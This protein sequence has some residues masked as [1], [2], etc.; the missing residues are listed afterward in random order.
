M[1]PRTDVDSLSRWL[2]SV[3][4]IGTSGHCLSWWNPVHPGYDYPEISGLLLSYLTRS[5]T[6]SARA[7]QLHGALSAAA[8]P[9]G[10]RRGGVHYAFDT[11][12]ALRGLVEQRDPERMLEAPVPAWARALCGW[13]E[14]AT[15]TEPAE[16]TGADTH[17]SMS[18]GAHQAKVAAGLIAL[19][20]SDAT[21]AD[22]PPDRLRAALGRLA[23]NTLELQEA[24]GR[25]RM[26]ARSRQ[27]YLHSHCYALEGLLMIGE[28]E[29]VPR[30]AISAGVGWLASVQRPDGGFAAWHDGTRPGGPVRT[31]ATAQA[32]RL[33]RLEDA[34][35]HQG[36]IAA[37]AGLLAALA[38][39][40][41]GLPY[42]PGS[43][44]LTSWSTMFAAQALAPRGHPLRPRRG[45]DLV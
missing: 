43:A 15:P 39:S 32:V 3:E 31:D 17:W 45:T 18:F 21:P 26:H 13:V 16:P 34:D 22:C 38:V 11:A 44:D 7:A 1:V 10:V 41:R 28:V 2:S 20:R 4:L 23:A 27:T 12:M 9:S 33:C 42:E 30:D 25:F 40:E 6:A 5:A 24:D 29:A 8:S 37:G 36:S 14:N 19:L 35:A